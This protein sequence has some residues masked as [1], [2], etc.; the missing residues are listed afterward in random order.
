M[1][2]EAR[3]TPLPSGRRLV[4]IGE[5]TMGQLA[6]VE[7]NAYSM[8]VMLGRE[9]QGTWK[10]Y[11]MATMT[12]EVPDRLA[13]QLRLERDRLPQ[14]LEFALRSRNDAQWLSMPSSLAFGEMVEFLSNRPSSDEVLAFKISP[15]A[16][17]RMASLLEKNREEGLSNAENGELDWYEYVHEIMTRLKTEVRLR[18]AA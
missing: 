14:L 18:T 15:S 11:A 8:I 7:R 10:G 9:L 17:D 4:A 1:V 13:V 6:L 12:L 16:Q 2:G 3:L 5:N